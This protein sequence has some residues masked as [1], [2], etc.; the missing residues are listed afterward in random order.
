MTLTTTLGPGTKIPLQRQGGH[1]VF[2][3]F[4]PTEVDDKDAA[5]MML[6][7]KQWNEETANTAITYIINTP[8][9][10]YEAILHDQVLISKSFQKKHKIRKSN[11]NDLTKSDL[12]KLHHYFG[13]CTVDRLEK[14]VRRAGRWKPELNEYF[15]EIKNCQVCA[16]EAKRKPLPKQ[17]FQEQAI[18]T[19]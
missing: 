7:T 8:E 19:N 2:T 11:K 1:Y 3:M 4:P 9:P 18:L 16:V 13:H 6:E 5:S 17:L 10:N 14:L 15:E 12:I